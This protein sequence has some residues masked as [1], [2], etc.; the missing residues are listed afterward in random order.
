MQEAWLKHDVA[1]CGYCQPGQIMA[2]V[3]ARS[4]RSGA[5]RAASSITDSDI[6]EIRNVC[7]CGTYP[8]I[9]EAIKEGAEAHVLSGPAEHFRFHVEKLRQAPLTR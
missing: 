4:T 5:T 8:R 2:A 1:Q 6:D 7:R 3:V 9:R